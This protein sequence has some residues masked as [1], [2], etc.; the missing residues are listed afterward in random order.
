MCSN[1]AA[2]VITVATELFIQYLSEAGHNVV[3]SERK[4]RKNI[5][6]RDLATAIARADNLEFLGDVVPKTMTY[7]Q[8]KEKQATSGKAR[9]AQDGAAVETGQTRL[10]ELTGGRR[11]ESGLAVGEEGRGAA[12]SRNANGAREDDG[13][14]MEEDENP[15]A[16]IA[17]ELRQ[18]RPSNGAAHAANASNEGDGDVEM[19]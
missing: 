11:R 9:K 7:K 17:M 14:D 8:V 1:N 6:Y 3:K 10:N 4:P 19:T 2:F 5:Q 12:G 13:E 15:N 18:A 16:Q